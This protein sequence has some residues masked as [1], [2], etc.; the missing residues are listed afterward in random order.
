[1]I[2]RRYMAE[3]LPIRRKTACNQSINHYQ[4]LHLKQFTQ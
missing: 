3:M 2:T 4:L 1:M